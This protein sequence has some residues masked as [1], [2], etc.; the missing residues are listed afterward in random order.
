MTQ[1]PLR[2]LL[3]NL[4]A[5]ARRI[6][7]RQLLAAVG[8]AG[9]FIILYAALLLLAGQER[10]RQAALRSE[11]AQQELLLTRPRQDLTE[12]ETRA[13]VAQASIPQAL[14][15]TEV[16]RAVRGIAGRNGVT[17]TTHSSGGLLGSAKIGQT[18]YQLLPFRL[19][20]AGPFDAIRS[21]IVD[22]TGQPEVPTLVLRQMTVSREKDLAR[23][24]L[25][26]VVY[27]QPPAGGR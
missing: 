1:R 21:F 19:S 2:R 25:D 3:L 6:Q 24:T 26:Y 10:D 11:I 5:T 20:A 22:L 15:D 14:Q 23:L 16:F 9:V 7:R 12:L 13:K 4:Q 27:I 18:L 8:V 17:I